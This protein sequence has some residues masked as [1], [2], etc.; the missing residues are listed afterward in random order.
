MDYPAEATF[1]V[2]L[3]LMLPKEGER[4]RVL[5]LHRELVEWLH[6]QPGF[7]RGYVI[8]AGDPAGR[9]GHLNVYESEEAAD[10]VAQT[11]HVLAVRADLLL[12]IDEGSQAERSYVAYDPQLAQAGR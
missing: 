11:Q 9:V 2:R 6:G 10:R 3:S 4:E 5:E 7:V 8:E 1:Y 12:L